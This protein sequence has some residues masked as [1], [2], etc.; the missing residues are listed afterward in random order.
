[1][2]VHIDNYKGKH[3]HFIGIGGCSMNGLARILHSRGYQVSGS[4]R[5]E[6]N[7]TCFVRSK[8]IPVSIG[9]N[10]KNVEGVDLIIYSAAIKPD[11]IERRRAEE[12]G[13]PQLERSELLGQLSDQ[14]SQV[15]GIAGCHGK[16]TIT[17]ML[18]L[19]LQKGGQDA[20]VHVGGETDFLESGV[21]IDHSPLFVT[22]ACEYV[23]SFLHLSPTMI[24]L[25]NID[26]D[27]LDYFK[28]IDAIYASFQKFVALLPPKGVLFGCTDDP[29]VN[30]LMDDCP[31]ELVRYGLNSQSG[32]SA[33]DIIY[34]EQGYPEFT[35]TL[36]GRPLFSVKLNVPG[37]YNIQNALAAISV[38]R[39]LG[40]EDK[41]IQ[42]ALEQYRL[43]KRRFELYGTVDGVRIYHDYAHHP[44]EITA[45][46]HAA[47]QMQHRKLWVVFQC[48]SYSRAITLF[49]KYAEAFH[50][51]DAVLIPDIYPG[52][53]QDTGLI[54][55]KDLVRGIISSC[56]DT[57]YIPTFEGIRDYLSPRWQA[58]DIVV[59]LG[60]GDVYIQARKLL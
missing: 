49:D 9:H 26:D 18:A 41:H 27:H 23:E 21:A 6:S 51:A 54:H 46:L 15:L 13:I 2:T 39:Y 32:Y 45:C 11:N 19:I 34:D 59:A 31:C 42:Q 37:L 30:R 43:A 48:N 16:T 58:G 4:D 44:S 29:L 20:T 53:E 25:N 47:A 33:A 7:F 28:N 8:G 10:E 1:M 50:D 22:E 35:C 3:L 36:N 14:F 55:A 24:V 5:I 52:R 38:A 56:A 57:L 40:I 60:S 12:L 17:S